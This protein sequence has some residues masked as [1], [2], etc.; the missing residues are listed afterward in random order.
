MA[1]RALIF[2][3]DGLMVDTELPIFQAWSAVYASYGATLAIDEWARGI[4]TSAD[5][6]DPVAELARQTGKDIHRE[7]AEQHYRS[8]SHSLLASAPAMP[9]VRER[10]AEAGA[11]GLTLAIASSSSRT[12]VEEHTVRLGLRH[13]FA[14]IRGA[15]DVARV[16]PD[17]GLYLSALEGLHV[18]PD[19]ALVLEDSPNGVLAANR[20]GVYCI[21]VPNELTSHLSL[22][23]AN[24]R[25]P[26]LASVTV[27]ELIEWADKNPTPHR[28]Q[29]APAAS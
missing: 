27:A 19:E 22:E 28:A 29:R 21:A 4:G 12:W 3:F 23:H 6:F 8:L 13:H 9:G 18:Q 14:L 16:K 5:A 1:V 20:A 7:G 15:E 24:R 10:I 11:L 2:D 26:S 17:P 25:I